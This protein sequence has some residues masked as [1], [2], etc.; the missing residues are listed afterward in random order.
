[1][2]R[3]LTLLFAFFV[4]LLLL[5][6]EAGTIASK[7]T[8]FVVLGHIREL[9]TDVLVLLTKR[10][11]SLRP[12]H[13]F[14]LGDLTNTATEPQRERIQLEFLDHLDAPY[15]V[16]PGNHDLIGGAEVHE[17]WIG[18]R[19]KLLSDP[20][21]NFLLFDSNDDSATLQREVGTLLD[22][23]E[24]T[25]PVILL[26]HH[27]VWKSHLRFISGRRV[28]K[29]HTETFWNAVKNRIDFAFAGDA[30]RKFSVEVRGKTSLYSVG[31]FFSGRCLPV[32]F[33][34]GVLDGQGQMQARPIYLDLPT[35]HPWHT[36]R[37]TDLPTERLR[38]AHRS[39]GSTG[40]VLES[41]RRYKTSGSSSCA[42]ILRPSTLR[43]LPSC[44]HAS[45]ALASNSTPL[46][47]S[48]V[49]ARSA[50]SCFLT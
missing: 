47:T 30:A 21:A 37:L 11:N 48:D 34:L 32:Y 3:F 7:P 4:P 43:E 10:I 24:P 42:G 6:C 5:G 9:P 15:H 17:S 13:I 22:L 14:I 40:A 1:V 39:P 41:P 12:D 19:Y 46:T 33:V 38:N 45:G 28:R 8:N 31:L 16:A 50:Y 26:G 36:L 2:R 44:T 20:N 27:W 35:M 23:A 18:Y 25:K 49:V 29:H